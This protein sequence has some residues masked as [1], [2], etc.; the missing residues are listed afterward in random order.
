[1]SARAVLRRCSCRVGG[2]TTRLGRWS[3]SRGLGSFRGGVRPLRRRG[4]CRRAASPGSCRAR[5][6]RGGLAR[7]GV[8]TTRRVD[9]DVT[10]LS[11]RVDQFRAAAA[12]Q[13]QPFVEDRLLLGHDVDALMAQVGESL[14]A[15]AQR[16]PARWRERLVDWRRPCRSASSRTASR[17]RGGRSPRELRGVPCGRVGRARASCGTS[18]RGPGKTKER[19]EA[20]RNAAG[21]LLAIKLPVIVVPAVSEERERFFYL[22]LHV[23]SSSEGL[24]RGGAPVA[25]GGGGSS[26]HA[27]TCERSSGP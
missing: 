13:Q 9:L 16:E 20:V 25:A 8:D 22:F 10:A 26:P 21:D 11:D 12:V 17:G 1:M 18:P 6:G 15:F 5:T 4:A 27:R 24:D 23:G 2:S 7:H 19:V 14:A 3:A